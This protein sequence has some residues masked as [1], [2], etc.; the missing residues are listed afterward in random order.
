[1]NYY[2]CKR[3][4]AEFQE[5]GEGSCSSCG[6]AKKEIRCPSCGSNEVKITGE[7]VATLERPWW[8]KPVR[9]G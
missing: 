6:T 7:A 3:C 4:K 5:E 9:F 8:D 1:M 2:E